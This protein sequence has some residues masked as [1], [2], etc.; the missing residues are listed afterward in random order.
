MGC[1][2]SASTRKV[3]VSDQLRT[4][5][6]RWRRSGVKFSCSIFVK[7]HGPAMQETL[8]LRNSLP[9]PASSDKEPI[10]PFHLLPGAQGG[11]LLHGVFPVLI[12][13]KVLTA[14][15]MLASVVAFTEYLI[16]VFETADPARASAFVSW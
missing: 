12:I 7:G 2:T 5:T 15:P 14:L 1:T 13:W 4:E 3:T 6:L 16:R 8:A 10:V 11:G 9:S